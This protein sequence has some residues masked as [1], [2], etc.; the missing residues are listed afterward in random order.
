MT[1]QTAI[2]VSDALPTS[3]PC[4]WCQRPAHK[5]VVIRERPRRL[6]KRTKVYLQGE[7][8]SE[9]ACPACVRR[10]REGNPELETL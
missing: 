10:L 1:G 7:P 5:R 8:V 9:W 3:G 2:R 6:D 4:G